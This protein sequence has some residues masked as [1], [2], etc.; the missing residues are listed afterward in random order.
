MT[1]QKAESVSQQLTRA[2][3]DALALEFGSQGRMFDSRH[4]ECRPAPPTPRSRATLARTSNKPFVFPPEILEAAEQLERGRGTT[5]RPATPA[6]KSKAEI[7]AALWAEYNTLGQKEK[8]LF[9]RANQAA[10]D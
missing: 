6:P 2:Q 8:V 3:L 4:A 10:M 5:D 1:T 7:K 9:Y